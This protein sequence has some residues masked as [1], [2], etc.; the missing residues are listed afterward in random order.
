MGKGNSPTATRY[1]AWESPITAQMVAAGQIGLSEPHPESGAIFWLELR[2]SEGGRYV[3]V[4]A[5][6]DGPVHDV[7]PARTN[8]R[9]RVH[10]YGGGAFLVHGETVFFSNFEDQRIYR[11]EAGALDPRPLTPE[12]PAPSAY[13]YADPR[14]TPDGRW[15][16]CVRERHGGGEPVNEIVAIPAGDSGDARIVAS[17]HDFFSN[18]RPSPDGSLLAWLAWDHPNMPWDGCELWVAELSEDASVGAPRHVAGGSQ[19]SIF[20]PDWSPDGVL[21]F[22]SDRTGWWNLYREVEGRVEPIAPR[23]EE[24]GVPAWQ[25]DMS[26]YAFLPEGRIACLHGFAHR[27]RLGILDPATG[28]IE[29]LDLPYTAYRSSLESHWSRL[30]FVGASATEPAGVVVVDTADGTRKVFRRVLGPEV[31]PEFVSVPR[32]IEFPTED[33]LTAHA[34]FYPPANRKVTGPRGE[35]PPLIVLSHGGPTAHVTPEFVLSNQFWTSRGFAVVDVNYGGSSGYGREYRQ[36]LN[37]NWGVVDVAD[38]VNAAKWLAGRGEVDGRRIAIRGGSAGGYCT[39]CALTFFPGV[40]GAGASYFGIGDLETF[41]N[42]THKFESRYLETLVGPY[43][44]AKEVYRERSPANFADQ[45]ACPVILFQGL[46]DLVVPPSQAEG[47]IRALEAKVIPYAY[48]PFEGEQ[49]GFRKAETIR[50]SLE[51][52]LFFY[53]KVFGFEPADSIEP[54]DIKNL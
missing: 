20:Q 43:P 39:L 10:E 8:V 11:L 7:T 15:L 47:M 18:P 34:L 46:E 6:D 49:H 2:P 37:G 4:R 16:V 52:E 5:T 14:L 54:V 3:V 44:E 48:I 30:A 51:A 21:H 13:R 32:P 45:I 33:G 26:T 38:C 41:V 50:R 9:T 35:R 53:G 25:F 22:V 23:E 31:D 36:R 42:D 40:F 29:D 17:G 12:P 19:E 24:F 1:G 27:T 28:R